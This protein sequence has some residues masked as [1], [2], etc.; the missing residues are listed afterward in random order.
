MPSVR[1]IKMIS[2]FGLALMSLNGKSFLNAKIGHSIK[3]EMRNRY[4]TNVGASRDTMICCTAIGMFP[5]INAVN[6][7]RKKPNL[8]LCTVVVM[9]SAQRVR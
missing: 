2:S 6:K 7:E 9:A 1:I 4:Q 3:N 5:H 8:A